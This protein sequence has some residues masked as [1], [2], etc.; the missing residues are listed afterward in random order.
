MADF[1]TL[2]LQNDKNKRLPANVLS[3]HPVFNPVRGK[4]DQMVADVKAINVVS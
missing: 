4:I 2:C 3:Q 1:L